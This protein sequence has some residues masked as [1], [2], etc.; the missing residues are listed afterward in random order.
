MPIDDKTRIATVL[1]VI[2]NHYDEASA[3]A[4]DGNWPKME[5]YIV[6]ALELLGPL[7]KSLELK[8]A[9]TG[10]RKFLKDTDN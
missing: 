2:S 3:A 6:S 1:K 5:R 10:I 7:A 4:R 9:A 8:E